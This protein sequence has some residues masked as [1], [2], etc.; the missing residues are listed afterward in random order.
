MLLL[1][2]SCVYAQNYHAVQGTSVAGSLNVANNPASIVNIP[3]PW[4]VVPLAMQVKNSTNAFTILRYSYLSSPVGS[5]YRINGGNFS[6]Y[7]ANN[8]NVHLLN[9]RVALGRNQAIAFGAN[10]RGYTG[11]ATSV[12]NFR[13]SMKTLRKFFLGNQE[14][15][16]LHAQI[17]TNSWVELFG[18]Y[19]RTLWDNAV[20][21]LNAGLT[22][23]VT[24]GLSGASVIL[25]NAGLLRSVRNNQASYIISSGNGSYAYSANYDAWKKQQSAAQNV[26][27]LV[28]TARKNL[29]F[30]LGVEYL[31]KPQTITGAEDE[32]T[33]Y[34]Y[35][36][37]LGFSLLDLGRIKYT[38][39]SQSRRIDQLKTD[40]FDSS[41]QRKTA[42]VHSLKGLNDSLASIV[43]NLQP[44][45]GTFYLN[46][47]ARLV[48][49][50][51]KKLTDHIFVNAEVSVNLSYFAVHDAPFVDEMNVV[52]LTPR[53]ESRRLGAYLPVLY[54]TH[55]QL[56]VGGA[57]RAGPLLLGFHNLAGFVSHQQA[58][59]GGGYLAF[60]IRP[61][62]NAGKDRDSKHARC[63]KF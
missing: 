63:P 11:A 49:N 45:T 33:Y 18:T 43:N 48:I 15:R 35:T 52:S 4:D 24:G 29:S 6:R 38:Y 40:I 39:G 19:S 61:G 58:Q 30:D 42:R 28:S 13:D 21:R 37:K 47:P 36:W 55:H 62:K 16:T 32:D 20:D 14:N 10:L 3:G 22:L 34:D 27:N 59:T 1:H 12:Y 26:Q 17:R 7:V 56:W 31:L 60:I 8:F 54:N 41:L 51:D 57:L 9:A 53:W 23:K 50:A 2:A 5:Q 46:Q 25:E 44:F